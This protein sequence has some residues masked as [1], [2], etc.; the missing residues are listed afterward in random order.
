MEKHSLLDRYRNISMGPKCLDAS[1]C[2]DSTHTEQNCDKE[3]SQFN[4]FSNKMHLCSL[5]SKYI[6]SLWFVIVMF[7]LFY[8][9]ST[10]T[11]TKKRESNLQT[12]E[13]SVWCG[14]RSKIFILSV[15]FPIIRYIM[16]SVALMICI[17]SLLFHFYIV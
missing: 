10:E 6:V 5:F 15:S 7:P 8:Y 17:Y 4:L 12:S 3:S 13:Q 11:C 9:T 14:E 16:C 1:V 2:L